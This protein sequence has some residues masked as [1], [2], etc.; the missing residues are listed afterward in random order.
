MIKY[1]YILICALCLLHNSCEKDTNCILNSLE[2]EHERIFPLANTMSIQ[3]QL[4]TTASIQSALVQYATEEDFS[5]YKE[6]EMNISANIYNVNIEGLS[7]NTTY[8][9]RFAAFNKYSNVISK[10]Q[11][12]IKTLEET[13]AH[14]TT[15]PAS[16]ISYHSAIVGGDIT[17]NGGKDITEYGIVYG[18]TTEQLDTMRIVGQCMGPFSIELNKL[19]EGTNYYASAY[20]I[21]DKGISYGQQISF[22]TNPYT[23]PDIVTVPAKDITIT[24]AVVCGS[25]ISD[26]GL[27]ITECGI[28]YGLSDEFSHSNKKIANNISYNF[29]INLENLSAGTIYYF[30]AYATNDYGTT[31]GNIES[32]STLSYEYVDL[33]LSVKWAT[34]NIGAERPEDYGH[35]FAWGEVTPKDDY[36]WENYK[37]CDGAEYQ[38]NKYCTSSTYFDNGFYDS[39]SQLDQSDD[40]AVVNWGGNWRMPTYG[41]LYSLSNNCIWTESSLNGIKGYMVTSKINNNS[42]FLPFAGGNFGYGVEQTNISGHYWSSTLDTR[43]PVGAMGISIEPTYEWRELWLPY[44]YCGY[45]IRPVCP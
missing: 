36:S 42:I 2:V 9:V 19:S 29:S 45:S 24:K 32:F 25:I 1:K 6:A 12:E 13:V 34:T 38:I 39:K 15:T 14:V 10:S 20:A 26:G 35:Y 43:G 18:K 44:R 27:E 28:R 31:Y 5:D 11:I 30:Q 23:S 33:G 21:N 17:Y 37:W 3:C 8:Y 4:V 16:N 7:A 40:A 41:E 22:T